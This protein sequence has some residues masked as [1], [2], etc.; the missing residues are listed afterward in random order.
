MTNSYKIAPLDNT[1]VDTM[2]GRYE[3]N[4]IYVYS[5]TI[6]CKR[7]RQDGEREVKVQNMPYGGDG[8][9]CMFNINV[10]KGKIKGGKWFED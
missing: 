6:E 3:L 4:M 7:A 9:Q 10:V 8:P 2:T 5:N 1:L